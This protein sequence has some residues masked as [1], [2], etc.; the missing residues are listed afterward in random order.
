MCPLTIIEV[1]QQVLLAREVQLDF[2]ADSQCDSL[3]RLQRQV[4][5]SLL[6]V[7]AHK[8]PEHFL[9]TQKKGRESQIKEQTDDMTK[10]KKT[11]SGRD[12]TQWDKRWKDL[13]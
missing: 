11:I 8:L 7:P 6:Q 4:R 9:C 13:L 5:Q 2:D 12:D 3:S 1:L 10:E